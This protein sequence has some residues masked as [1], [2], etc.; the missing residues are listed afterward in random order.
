MELLVDSGVQHGV[1]RVKAWVS[2][3]EA[4]TNDP[5]VVYRKLLQ[6]RLRFYGEIITNR[7]QNASFAKGWMIRLAE[8][9]R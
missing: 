6:T 9:V 3:I 8:Y 2:A 5:Q 7:P 1:Q 4:T